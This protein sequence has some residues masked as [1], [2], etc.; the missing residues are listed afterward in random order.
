MTGVILAGGQNSR[1]PEKKAFIKINGETILSR[2]LRI[3]RRVFDQILIS[4]N[5]PINY[6]N[7]KLP[8]IGD[9]SNIS[10][11]MTGILSSLLNAQTD[12]IFVI[13]CDMPFVNEELIRYLISIKDISIY[14][15]IVPLFNDIPQPLFSIYHKRLVPILEE[16]I[17]NG[18]LSLKKMLPIINCKYILEEVICSIDKDGSSFININTPNDFKNV[19]INNR[20]K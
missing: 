19:I 18:Q 7:T 12:Q 2:N 10:G 13:A 14:D 20:N 11:P 16:H 6:F 15:A 17:K 1:Y 4:T 8:L 5:D 3:F 9:V